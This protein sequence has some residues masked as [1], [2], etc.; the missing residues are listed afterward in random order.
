M[1]SRHT[2]PPASL[3]KDVQQRARAIDLLQGHRARLARWEAAARRTATGLSWAE[4]ALR[5]TK[6]PPRHEDG[7]QGI[8]DPAEVSALEADLRECRASHGAAWYARYASPAR[9]ALELDPRRLPV[10]TGGPH[11]DRPDAIRP[12]PYQIPVCIPECGA[13]GVGAPGRAQAT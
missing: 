13:S 10:L 2:Q 11:F 3:A 7:S 4:R 1:A 9:P 12:V 8:V 6:C 5:V